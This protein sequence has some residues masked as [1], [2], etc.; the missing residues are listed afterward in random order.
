MKRVKIKILT[1]QKV[2]DQSETLKT[3]A[4]GILESKTNTYVLQYQTKDDT[5]TTLTVDKSTPKAV[6]CHNGTMTIEQGA[7]HIAPY[8]MG[9]YEMELGVTGK[10]VLC[11]LDANGGTIK[12]CYDLTV[13]GTPTGENTVELFVQS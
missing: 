1:T 2:D 5:P 7:T 3:F 10:Q 13:N 9:P 4:F 11:R 12:L 8:Q 6:M